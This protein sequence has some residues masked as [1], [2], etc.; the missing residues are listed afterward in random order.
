[1]VSIRSA[2]QFINEARGELFT[3]LQDNDSEGGF[4]TPEWS[5]E[6]FQATEDLKSA[7]QHLDHAELV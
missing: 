3:L 6:I 5:D 2:S 7:Q 1:V 4:A